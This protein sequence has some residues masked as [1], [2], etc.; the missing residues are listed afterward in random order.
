MKNQIKSQDLNSLSRC[1]MAEHMV[2]HICGHKRIHEIYGANPHN[3]AKWL[4][5]QLCEACYKAEQQAK[6]DV[7]NKES[8]IYNIEQGLPPLKGTKKQVAWAETIRAEKIKALNGYLTKISVLEIRQDLTP[9]EIE[10]I[11]KVKRLTQIWRAEEYAS[12]W[13]NFS[14][15]EIGRVLKCVLKNCIRLC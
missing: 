14:D 8:A 1:V 5:K 7:K 9:L 4:A 6:N 12:A 11:N 15:Q 10:Q 3:I 2:K 13:I